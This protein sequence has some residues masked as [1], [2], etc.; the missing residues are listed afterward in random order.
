MKQIFTFLF[1][2]LFSAQ[3]LWGQ[4]TVVSQALYYTSSDTNG[5]DYVKANTLSKYPGWEFNDWCYAL[6]SNYLQVGSGSDPYNNFGI[7]TTPALGLNGN[8][9]LILKTKKIN[10]ATN[11]SFKVSIV[12]EGTT[13]SEIYTVNDTEE[14]RPSAI[15]IRNCTPSTRIRIE[16]TYGKFILMTMKVYDIGSAIFYESFNNMS[17]NN[18]FYPS[19][20]SATTELCDNWS[21]TTISSSDVSQSK[22]N[23]YLERN[24]SQYKISSI[25][26]TDHSNVILSFKIA[27][28]N[29]INGIKITCDG[30]ARLSNFNSTN[31]SNVSSS[32]AVNAL[33]DNYSRWID[34]EMIVTN[35]NNETTLTF[36]GSSM[37]LDDV[38]LTPIPSGL[39]QNSDNS[40]YIRG[41]AGQV[42]DVQ[43]QRTLT[44]NVWCPLCLPFDVTPEKMA[45]VTG[46]ACELNT[47]ESVAEGVFNFTTVTAGTTINAGTPFLVKTASTVTNPTFTG[48]TIRN[49][50]AGKS[51]EGSYWFVGNYSPVYLKTDGTNLFLGTDGDLYKP[52]TTEGYNRFGGLRA[53]F[54]I[55]ENTEARVA[56]HHDFD[57]TVAIKSLQTDG[58]EKDVKTYDLQGR[59]VAKG[60]SSRN[61]LTIRKGRKYLAK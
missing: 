28:I 46:T 16:G 29:D 47:L 41:N 21:N 59:Q 4:S 27:H 45:T 7:V 53:Y 10:S 60:Q 13:S 54:D 57:G 30:D 42:R 52:G 11:G 38:M 2:V 3:G 50:E 43:L 22:Q 26:V 61:R 17:G 24:G 32:R 15:L 36:E 40:A 51:G 49:T 8:A 55:P 48:V 1:V 56:F 39:D 5:E 6:K 35:M 20:N 12:G 14:Y 44:A 58:L 9:V 34:Y 25:P 33:S 19:N 37:S 23:I 18:E 31:I